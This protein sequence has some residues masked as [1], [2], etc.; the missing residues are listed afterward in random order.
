MRNQLVATI[1]GT[2]RIEFTYDGAGRRVRRVL[3]E[4]DVIAVDLRLIWCKG[5]ICEQRGSEGSVT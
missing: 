1:A 4:N 5:G 2:Q 3:R